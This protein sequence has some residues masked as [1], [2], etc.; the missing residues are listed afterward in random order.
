VGLA[1]LAVTGYDLATFRPRAVRDASTPAAFLGSNTVPT[2]LFNDSVA[3][4]EN[5][6]TLRHRPE[7]GAAAVYRRDGSVF[8]SYLRAGEATLRSGRPSG[9]SVVFERGR[10]VLT[11]ALAS[12]NQPLG[13]LRLAYD[14]PTLPQRLPQYA[15][16]VALVLIGIGSTA[17]LLL[18]ALGR[19]VATPLRGLAHALGRLTETRDLTVR[20][21]QD[22][23]DEIGSL[24]AAFNRMLD[25]LQERDAALRQSEA[26]LRLAL[27][28]ADMETWGGEPATALARLLAAAHPDDRAAVEQAVAQA[29]AANSTLEIEFRALRDASERVI[30]LRGQAF[31]DGS[32]AAPQLMG[33]LQDVTGRRRLEQQLLQSQKM[34]AIGNLAGGIAHDFNNLLTGMLGYLAFVRQRL[35]AASPLAADVDQVERAARRA[36][37]L[38]SQLLSYARRQ[39]VVPTVVDMN[40]SVRALEPMLARLLGEGVNVATELEPALWPA[41]VDPGQ[42]EQVIVNL[43]VNGRD[44]MPAGGRLTL[45]T[46]NV[47]L[48]AAAERP[49]LPAGE[50][51]ELAVTDAG[52]GIA[53]DIIGRIFEPFFTTKPLGQ[54][55]G[56]GLSVCYGI[57]KQA[58]GDLAV[59]SHPGQGST[60]RMLLPRAAEVPRQGEPTDEDVVGGHETIL[61]VEDDIAV[62]ELA[63]RALRD[64]GYW[65]LEAD[66]GPAAITLA[67]EHPGTIDLL[68]T[69]VVMPQQSGGVLAAELRRTRPSLPVLFMSGYPDDVMVRRGVLVSEA[70]FLGKPF[71]PGELRRAARRAIDA[72]RT[73]KA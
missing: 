3:A 10:L 33:V 4:R 27:T 35:P 14:L 57:A 20:V 5:L 56:L 43:A 39:M 64:A 66:D 60:F 7:I 38:T 52:T 59:E 21:P 29:V 62:R 73:A 18:T 13:W 31:G 48:A 15:V 24:T 25:T 1:A 70:P 45:A 23:Q 68:L 47:V 54:G 6:A 37:A 34:E 41:R 16:V 50:Y 49:D 26:R 22:A 28:A 63:G 51:A 65:V 67:G 19:Y 69:D 53:P 11:S 58:G 36:A 44:A 2:L 55:T 46:R 72:T 9:E 8:A 40:Q 30:A 17:L 61:L 42:L 71:T 32:G 12:D